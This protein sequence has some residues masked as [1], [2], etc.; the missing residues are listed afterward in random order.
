M[1][2]EKILIVEDESIV[3][4]DIK[5]RLSK[6]GYVVTGMASSAEKALASIEQWLPDLILMDIHIKGPM[7]GI[8]LASVLNKKYNIP[9]IFLTANSEASTINK[10]KITKPYGYL[11]KPFSER[12]LNASIQVALQRY[13]TEQVQRQNEED[14]SMALAAG[15]LTSWVSIEGTQELLIEKSTD[16]TLQT[17]SSWQSFLARVDKR[18]L[19]AVEQA[20]ERLK[21]GEVLE[22]ETE[23]RLQ[24]ELN[25]SDVKSAEQQWYRLYGR[26]QMD[27]SNRITRLVGV[28]Q[29]VTGR[30]QVEAKLKQASSIFESSAEGV[31]IFNRQ[32]EIESCNWAFAQLVG[33]P[34][35]ELTGTRVPCLP[36]DPEHELWQQLAQQGG[37]QGNLE[38]NSDSA[39]PR[40]FQI[41][42]SSL[43]CDDHHCDYVMMVADVS[44]LK[45]ANDE[46]SRIAYYDPLTGLPN[47]TLLVSRLGKALVTAQQDNTMVAVMF[48]DL[49]GF[50]QVNDSFGHQMGDKVLETVAQ[51]IESRV[52]TCDTVA[53]FGGDEFILVLEGIK[54]GRVCERLADKLLSWIAKPVQVGEQRVGVG[55]SIG[56]S[57][58]PK[59]ALDADELI[60][61]ADV[62]MYSAKHKGKCKISYFDERLQHMLE[63]AQVRKES[64]L[65]ALNAHQLDMKTD[66]VLGFIDRHV[67]YEVNSIVWEQADGSVLLVDELLELALDL[68]VLDL[69]NHAVLCRFMMQVVSRKGVHQALV[70]DSRQLR[71]PGFVMT[72]DALCTQHHIEAS[73]ILIEYLEFQPGER[74]EVIS[75]LG[76]LRTLGVRCIL[77]GFGRGSICFDSFTEQPPDYIK[78]AVA[79]TE[80]VNGNEKQQTAIKALLAFCQLFN[81]PIIVCGN[82]APVQVSLLQALGCRFYQISVPPAR[83]E[84]QITG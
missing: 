41:H 53:R 69:F 36:L 83:D 32:F 70:V 10:A 66:C 57:L 34:R 73:Q 67:L 38:F 12:E 22:V 13:E 1:A 20:L 23:F 79:L 61:K 7:D 15:D 11:L 64:Y 56:V 24:K 72:L 4:F 50:K 46:L 54:D 80:Y 82:I 40:F 14:L 44:A 21:Q 25:V 35:S 2:G 52:R 74:A 26:A 62:A 81:I 19:T 42:V 60:E 78:L 84:A 27:Q 5:R 63:Q 43:N 45:S 65:S 30:H 29:D 6:F 49:D 77:A 47:R 68:D 75:V 28:L 18:D 48:I 33:Q 37:W 31:V 59:D 3:A 8:E 9:I 16:G 55:A 17:H 39:P 71:D 76:A 58:Y 51:R